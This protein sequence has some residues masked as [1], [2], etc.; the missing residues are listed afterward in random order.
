MAEQDFR[1][2][3]LDKPTP[4]ID[5]SA[6][7][8]F[9]SRILDPKEPTTET[10]TQ[11]FRANILDKPEPSTR[12]QSFFKSLQ[13]SGARK[14][15]SEDQTIEEPQS[16][17]SVIREKRSGAR[18]ESVEAEQTGDSSAAFEAKD[19]FRGL[20]ALATDPRT[21][22][23]EQKLAGQEATTDVLRRTAIGAKGLEKGLTLGLSEPLLNMLSEKVDIDLTPQSGSEQVV[24]GLSDLIGSVLSGR[25]IAGG[26]SGLKGVGALRPLSRV[27]ATRLLTSG[28]SSGVRN[29]TGVATGDIDAKTAAANFG[30]VLASSMIG[31]VPEQT[32]PAG[33]TNWLAQVGTDFAAD[34]LIDGGLRGRLDDQSFMDWFINEEVPQ[35][36]MSM[37]FATEDLAKGKG[38]F[39]AERKAVRDD[40]MSRFKKDVAEAEKTNFRIEP[41]TAS[42]LTG[43]ES[44][45]PI[46][47]DAPRATGDTEQKVLANAQATQTR[48]GILKLAGE[49]TTVGARPGNVTDITK[50]AEPDKAAADILRMIKDT[51][52]APK[53]VSRRDTTAL[54]MVATDQDIRDYNKQQLIDLDR[55]LVAEANDAIR[56]NDREFLGIV[57]LAMQ[58]IEAQKAGMAPQDVIPGLLEAT[59]TSRE[60]IDRPERRN[61]LVQ[62]IDLVNRRLDKLMKAVHAETNLTVGEVPEHLRSKIAPEPD[63]TVTRDEQA[64]DGQPLPPR[65][66]DDMPQVRATALPDPEAVA[67]PSATDVQSMNKLQLKETASNLG[68]KT[69]G[70]PRGL[71]NRI[72]AELSQDLGTKFDQDFNRNDSELTEALKAEKDPA[73]AQIKRQIVDQEATIKDALTRAGARNAVMKKSLEKGSSANAQRINKSA[74][75]DLSKAIPKG[76][77]KLFAKYIDSLRTIEAERLQGSRGVALKSR[78]GTNA[79]DAQ[80]WLN[81]FNTRN[82][83]ALVKQ[84]NEA[85]EVY[86]GTL[87][88]QLGELRESG[89]ISADTEQQLLADHKFYSPRQFVQ[90]VDPESGQ[91]KGSR[92]H[93]S[94]IKT[95]KEGSEGAML[96]DPGIL[97]SEVIARTQARTFR[98]KSNQELVNAVKSNTDLG[99]V[100]TDGESVRRGEGEVKA[101]FDGVEE[102]VAMP[103]Q[104]AKEWNGQ[105]PAMNQTVANI[106]GWV[107]GTKPLKFIAT[108]ANPEFALANLPRDMAFAWFN[109][110]QYS[111]FLPKCIIQQVADYTGITKDAFLRKGAYEDYIKEGGGMDYLSTQGKKIINKPW[112]SRGKG[113]GIVRSTI[114]VLAYLGETSEIATRLAVRKRAI[115]N[116]LSPEEAT[117]QARNMLDFA[118]GGRTSKAIDS[119]VPYFNA[120]IQGTRGT[121]RTFK[122]NPV[123][124][125]F[126]AAQLSAIGYGIAYAAQ[127]LDPEAWD[128]ISDREKATKWVIPLGFSK[129]D[130][131]GNKKHAY[132]AIPKDQSQQF[133]AATGQATADAIAGKPWKPELIQS[134][135][136]LFPTEGANILPPTANA[137]KAYFDNYDTWTKDKVWR[138]YEDISPSKEFQ[139]TTPQMARDI[140]NVAAKMKIPISPE[141]LSRATS[142]LIPTSNPVASSLIDIYNV[143]A[144]KEGNDTMV[145]QSRKIPGLRRFIRF[146]RS[147]TVDERLSGEAKRFDLDANGK[148]R[149]VLQGEVKKAKTAQADDRQV[150]N[151]EL[152]RVLQQ[153]NTTQLDVRK[154]INK[155]TRSRTERQR[156]FQ[157]ASSKR[158]DLITSTYKGRRRR[159][160]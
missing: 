63:K 52:S 31:L 76:R 42:E 124:A 74:Q 153:P 123:A 85:A 61:K 143:T 98:N 89:L 122:T 53:S 119:F 75:N 40:F 154:F 91:V 58:K 94:G 142:K 38:N 11:D 32:V 138:G 78:Q 157:R 126:K 43:N 9:A 137:Y 88:G 152:D 25:A 29:L 134:I 49:L 33:V 150:L 66:T 73:V 135:G 60:G 7:Q 28:L 132:I 131:N 145:E 92:V 69:S 13:S 149:Q 90:F 87:R 62:P 15:V 72:D 79:K 45:T 121:F 39:D 103:E 100:L 95:L 27:I 158:S 1:A 160:R 115:K 80:Q 65:T 71:R 37:T 105:D 111:N 26:I 19:R 22:A 102:R 5:E 57:T 51:G 20:D 155:A 117:F 82:D 127:A 55:E 6:T 118:Q 139:L 148:T 70:T 125:S 35:L 81:T 86:W 84:I 133:F 107:S 67:R 99:R 30:Q 56:R 21:A 17:E 159:R 104:L 50:S 156:L 129:T 151:V 12:A 59:I 2:N 41:I 146:S 147:A 68:L 112:E 113:D 140:S 36:A 96:S 114:D 8:D 130:K 101:F 83:P 10:Q 48:E 116:G 144:S 109:S 54:K 44:L 108:G 77:Q 141:R 97:M 110:G 3:I 120:A 93:D 18:R 24:A 128:A 47:P 4:D 106:L 136:A 34:L 46:T 64:L 16:V 14:Q 23:I